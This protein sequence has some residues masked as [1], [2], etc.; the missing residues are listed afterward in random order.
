[1]GPLSNYEKAENWC[2]EIDRAAHLTLTILQWAFLET[3]DMEVALARLAAF[4]PFRN[5]APFDMI[6]PSCLEEYIPI[7]S[8]EVD[9]ELFFMKRAGV[10]QTMD[11]A[12]SIAEL[13]W[14]ASEHLAQRLAKE[15]KGRW[16]KE[17]RTQ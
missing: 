2:A 11:P 5:Q 16:E 15:I 14:V 4:S 8:E 13:I 6:R 9:D 3:D 7:F 12:S 10:L 17:Q 1:M